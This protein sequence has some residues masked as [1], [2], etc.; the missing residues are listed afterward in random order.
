M[1][2]SEV[3]P[4]FDPSKLPPE[5]RRTYEAARAARVSSQE[6]KSAFEK[7]IRA[8]YKIEIKF[9]KTRT[10]AG[11]N[12]LM[13][14]VFESGKH[15]HG[16]GDELV[17]WCQSRKGEDGCKSLISGN[18]IVHGVAYCPGC[19]AMVNAELLT[20]QFWARVHIRKLAEYMAN[21]W[22]T[23]LGCSADI[24]C[25]YNR[26]DIRYKIM[27]QKVGAERARALQGLCI[28]PLSNILKDTSAGASLETRIEA[29]LK[30]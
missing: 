9:E 20:A 4:N 6:A 7:D 21:L 2:F 17:Y 26:E 15:L 18:N 12:P 22:R 23:K 29:F 8:R 19:N 28:Y 11:L 16:G 24:Y 27:E 3:D 13:W 5:L 14:Q 10:M 1:A 30:A 25:K